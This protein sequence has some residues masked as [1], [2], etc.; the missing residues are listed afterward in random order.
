MGAE[1]AKILNKYFLFTKMPNLPKEGKHI[2]LYFDPTHAFIFNIT[3][4]IN[5]GKL[6]TEINDYLR[7]FCATHIDASNVAC[8]FCFVGL[9]ATVLGMDL[10]LTEWKK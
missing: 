6:F 7:K 2:Y 8:K 10:Y 4:T 5:C 1:E 3:K 9:R